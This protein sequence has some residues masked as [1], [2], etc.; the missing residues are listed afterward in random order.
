MGVLCCTEKGARR[1]EPRG[2]LINRERSV[3]TLI[4]GLILASTL[5]TP[6]AAQ[7]DSFYAGKTLK[8]L[9]G[10]QVGGTA[11]T[12]VRRFSDYLRKHLPGHPA[13]IVE[14]M[15]AIA[16]HRCTYLLA[17]SDSPGDRRFRCVPL[18]PRPGKR[19]SIRSSLQ[20]LRRP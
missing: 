10:V 20:P 18:W 1:V 16:A 15:V 13:V 5:A 8:V 3:R 9:V 12:L 14:N 2:Q 17:L 11:D 4:A 7:P 6:A 19:P